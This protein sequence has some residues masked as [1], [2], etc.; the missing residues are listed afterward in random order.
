MFILIRQSF[1][2]TDNPFCYWYF[3][4][5]FCSSMMVHC[6]FH[7][8]LERYFMLYSTVNVQINLL[9]L[10]TKRVRE[11]ISLYIITYSKLVPLLSALSSFLTLSLSFFLSIPFSLPS[12]P[13]FLRLLAPFVHISIWVLIG[14]FNLPQ[15]LL[16]FLPNRYYIVQRLF[17]KLM[18]R[19]INISLALVS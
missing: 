8:Y 19:K 12:F 13:S 7:Y 14:T 11:K 3:F 2:Q 9:I 4:F 6:R 1:S 17:Y 16:F 15:Q 18:K 5:W 10:T